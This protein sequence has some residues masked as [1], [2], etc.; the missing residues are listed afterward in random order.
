MNTGNRQKL[1]FGCHAKKL[2]DNKTIK[3]LK[4]DAKQLSDLRFIMNEC[5]CNGAYSDGNINEQ[6]DKLEAKG[7]PQWEI[8]IVSRASKFRKDKAHALFKS[9]EAHMKIMEENN[10]EN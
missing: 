3:A 8:D 2:L 5:L 10:V 6:I 7:V 4:R 9:L 1:K